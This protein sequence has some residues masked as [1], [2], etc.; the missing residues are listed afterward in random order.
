MALTFVRRSELPVTT[1]GKAPVNNVTITDKGALTLSSLASEPFGDNGKVF[2]AF[3][4]PKCMIFTSTSPVIDKAIKGKKIDPEGFY[5]MKKPK[6]GN[7][8]SYS[9]GAGTLLRN[10]KQFGA[11]A[12]YDFS[13][14]GY[15]TFDCAWDAKNSMLV[16][17]LPESGSLPRRA[18]AVRA[19]RKKKVNG[20]VNGVAANPASTVGTPAPAPAPAA[21]PKSEELDIT[22]EA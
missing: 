18:Q 9:F 20:A 7:K 15:Q 3:D 14:S 6:N 2:V 1:I 21:P 10:A 17:N 12:N 16:F 8:K 4:G 19:P 5:E 13:A 11:S 22:L